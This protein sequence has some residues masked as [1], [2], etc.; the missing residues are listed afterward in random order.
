[1]P[2]TTYNPLWPVVGGTQALSAVSAAAVGLTITA[3]SAASAQWSAPNYAIFY[4]EGASARWRDD[5]TDP[6][7]TVGMPLPANQY[8]YY[9]GRLSSFRLI[10]VTG[11]T[12]VNCALYRASP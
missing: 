3:A 8:F 12:I 11:S 1:M 2:N 9:E 4:A 7:T 10:G 5:G 6:T